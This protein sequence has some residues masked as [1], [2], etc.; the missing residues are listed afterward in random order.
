MADKIDGL[1]AGAGDAEAQRGYDPEEVTSAKQVVQQLVRTCKTF[2]IYLP[3]NPIHQKFLDELSEKVARHLQ[4]FG[5]L[6]LRV[7][8]FELLCSG[9]PVYEDPDRRESIAF[10]LSADG[11]W[12]ISFLPG[13][14]KE[15]LIGFLEVIGGAG[16]G[17]VDD[18]IVTLLWG[19]SLAHIKY[20][21]VEELRGDAGEEGCKEMRAAPVSPQQ[22]QEVFSKEVHGKEAASD[23]TAFGTAKTAEVPSLHAFKLSDDELER[24][25]EE[26]HREDNLDMVA[27]LEGLLFDVLRIERDPELFSEILAMV[28][29]ILESLLLRGDFR[30]ARRLIEFHREMLEPTANL[31]EP[32]RAGLQN[33]LREAG[34]PKRISQLQSILDNA[35]DEALDDFSSL[36]S[37]L[38]REV[39]SPLVDLLGNLGKMKAR[40]FLCDILVRIGREDVADLTSRLNDHRWYLVRNLIYILGNIGDKRVLKDLARFARHDTLQVR[41]AVFHALSGMDDPEADQFLLQFVSD[42]DYSN[43]MSAIKSLGRKKVRGALALLLKVLDSKDFQ[44][45]QLGEKKEIIEAIG[46]TG[47][48]SVVPKLREL[49]Q[50]SWSLFK[51]VKAEE[52]ACCAAEALQKIATP[53]ASGALRE[54]SRSKNKTVREACDKALDALKALRTRG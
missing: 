14:Q 20:S 27:E 51:D 39:I 26:V 31:P 48:E 38:G 42:S 28:D 33:A 18:D 45:K 25:K 47:G 22:L 1:S 15:E 23:R 8:Q 6:K 21:V 24:V 36:M 11:I 50:V 29:G 19:K 52:T 35:E 10:K 54:G 30:H 4:A 16:G 2:K 17:Q 34:N 37:L 32:L 44:T 5:P 40:R 53:S 7:R 41:R 46:S 13:V 12:E 43:R 49:L 9:Q 3:N